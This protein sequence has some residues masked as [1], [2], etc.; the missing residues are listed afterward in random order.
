M[1]AILFGIVSSV[2][3]VQDLKALSPIFLA[4]FPKS[5][6]FTYEFASR[7]AG[8][9]FT[10]SPKITD[11]LSAFSPAL[12]KTLFTAAQLLALNF[13]VLRLLKL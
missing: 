3:P 8:T 13:I 11:K 9:M 10:L 4:V 12:V 7:P 6:F 5:M 1:V 2:I